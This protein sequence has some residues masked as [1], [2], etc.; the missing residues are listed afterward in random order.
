MIGDYAGWSPFVTVLT[1]GG[2][3]RSTE[4]AVN[5]NVSA[6][7]VVS[8]SNTQSTMGNDMHRL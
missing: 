7:C 3:T 6:S 1:Y 4:V 8:P 5:D 2:F